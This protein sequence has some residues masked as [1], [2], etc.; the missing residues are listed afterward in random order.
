MATLL[1][2]GLW[3]TAAVA[4]LALTAAAAARLFRR[5]AQTHLLWP[6]VLLTLLAPPDAVRPARCA[7][8]EPAAVAPEC[9][10]KISVADRAYVASKIYSAIETYF[11][12]R[13]G[14]AGLDLDAAYRAYLD[15]AMAAK[16]RREFD[17]ATL[18]FVAKLRNKH[19]Q[20]DDEWLRR[21]Y[22]QPLGFSALPVED[23]W[24]IASARDDR[25]KKG[26][27]VRAI[28]GVDITTFV[29]DRQK[30]VAASSERG[31]RA[32]VFD[33]AYLFPRRFTLELEGG[34]KVELE[35]GALDRG[36]AEE[37]RP[38]A[39]AGRWLST[40]AVGYI[41]VPSWNDARY[42]ESAIELVRKY[43][44]AGWLVI[45]LRGNGGGRTPF[46]LI[47]ELMNVEWRYWRTSTPSC[48]ALRRAQ[49]AAPAYLRTDSKTFRPRAGAFGG[50]LIILVDRFSCSATE[51]FVMPFR[52][53]GRAQII[54]ET[55]EG[56]SGQPYFFRF[57]NGMSIMVGS[58]RYTFPDGSPFESV[59]IKPTIPV[60]L[61]LADVRDGVDAA[62]RKAK[63]I[64]GARD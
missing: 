59:G 17:L 64:A 34:R 41:K 11:A 49:G 52:D 6:L 36:P 43:R 42:E 2:I 39:S 50:R 40:G 33:R 51:D 46:E 3:N 18:E 20:F 8:A 28:D 29:R 63:E 21:E 35:R 32:L 23:R 37:A 60:E 38:P 12:H 25:L 24:V 26:A 14:V 9:E 13:E 55:T 1:E 4:V 44:R 19:T 47:G 48:V 16:G 57:G 58:V 31:A 10:D 30:Y 62:L 45:D 27:V 22:G 54:G 56:S 5:P 15:G 53:N 61:R 7:A